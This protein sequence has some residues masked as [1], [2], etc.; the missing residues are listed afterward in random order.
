MFSTVVVCSSGL[1]CCC[2]NIIKFMK[3]LREDLLPH[4]M[5]LLIQIVG[6][7]QLAGVFGDG[8]GH[9]WRQVMP[10]HKKDGEKKRHKG[11]RQ[12]TTSRSMH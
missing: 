11:N 7:D 12:S 1:G 8:V 9:R 2:V 10:G 5:R 6:G 4:Q 3:Y